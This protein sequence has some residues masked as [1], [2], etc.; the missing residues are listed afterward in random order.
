MD[1]VL[2]LHKLFGGPNSKLSA[3]WWKHI[4]PEAIAVPAIHQIGDSLGA[5]ALAS[6]MSFL[7][8]DFPIDLSRASLVSDLER[9]VVGELVYTHDV[10]R[11][12]IVT[13]DRRAGY[14]NVATANSTDGK[15]PDEYGDIIGSS[16]GVTTMSVRVLIITPAVCLL[17]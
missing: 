9:L 8:T 11:S 6:S 1:N 12:T 17:I 10:V 14:M 2:D 13:K 15:V 7:V 3:F 16:P 5:H 4:I